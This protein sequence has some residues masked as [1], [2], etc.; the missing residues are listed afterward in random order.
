MAKIRRRNFPVYAIAV[1]LGQ[2]TIQATPT[3]WAV[4]LIRDPVIQYQTPSGVQ[5][6]SSYWVSQFDSV[7]SMVSKKRS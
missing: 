7:A 6:R 5:Q 1:D 4:G 3:V 2:V